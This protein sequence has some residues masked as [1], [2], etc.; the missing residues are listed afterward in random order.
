MRWSCSS[1]YFLPRIEPS[2]QALVIHGKALDGE[3]LDDAGGPLAELHGA[4][5]VHLVADGDDGG[6]V[7]VLGVV[8][9]AVGGS[10]SKISNN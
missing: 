10:Y 2:F 5:R 4:F 1:K 3:G 9:F 6:E 8:G 7:V